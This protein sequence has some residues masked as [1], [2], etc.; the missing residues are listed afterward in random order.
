MCKQDGNFVSTVNN[1][2][3]DD[4]GLQLVVKSNISKG[5]VFVFSANQK[6]GFR[7]YDMEILLVDKW[8]FDN[9]T[10]R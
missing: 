10:S 4:R 8:G 2:A 3:F 1:T 9:L 5:S 6:S 7:Y